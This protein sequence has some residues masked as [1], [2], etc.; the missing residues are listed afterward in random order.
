MSCLQDCGQQQKGNEYEEVLENYLAV[1]LI[2][3]CAAE[4][5]KGELT[6]IVMTIDSLSEIVA[7]TLGASDLSKLTVTDSDKSHGYKK[8]IVSLIPYVGGLAAEE[9]QQ[10]Y[11]RMMSSSESL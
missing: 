1:L 10:Y 6:V 9:L 5:T 2:H 11:I 3:V 7:Q 4:E 8:A